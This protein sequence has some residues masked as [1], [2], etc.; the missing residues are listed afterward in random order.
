MYFAVF[1][2][3]FLFILIDVEGRL[4]VY[5]KSVFLLISKDLL[6]LHLPVLRQPTMWWN[7]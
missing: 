1:Y 5:T 2:F 7:F 3:L 6:L 4:V